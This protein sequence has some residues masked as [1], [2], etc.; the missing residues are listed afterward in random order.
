MSL[1]HLGY[2]T[3][4][5]REQHVN[6][7][8]SCIYRNQKHVYNAKGRSSRPACFRYIRRSL[9]RGQ[10]PQKLWGLTGVG[11]GQ[12]LLIFIDCLSLFP[13]RSALR[14]TYIVTYQCFVYIK[15][16]NLLARL[17]RYS[18]TVHCA[19]SVVQYNF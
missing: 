8:V 9:R 2:R 5:H 3:V 15:V 6:W 12:N 1:L 10:R 16:W 13:S 17:S 14:N 7:F 18:T 4:L 19:R 11:A